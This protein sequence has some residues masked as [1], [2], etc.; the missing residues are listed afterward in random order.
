[1]KKFGF[2]LL[3]GIT[4]TIAAAAAAGFTYHK[5]EIEPLEEEQAKFDNTELKS[6]RKAA[7]SHGSRY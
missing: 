1:M 4:G 3:T 6:A 7:H 2:G 5:I